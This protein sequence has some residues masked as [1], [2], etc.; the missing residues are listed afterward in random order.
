MVRLDE[1]DEVRVL[2]VVVVVLDEHA[3]V[4]QADDGESVAGVFVEGPEGEAEGRARTGVL[5]W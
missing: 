4:L 2:R 3:L 1:G 5:A